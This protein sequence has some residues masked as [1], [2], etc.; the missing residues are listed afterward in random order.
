MQTEA[1]KHDPS[2]LVAD[3]TKLEWRLSRIDIRSPLASDAW[4]VARLEL[5]HPVRG[6]VTDIGTAPGAFDAAFAAASQILAISP[7]LLAFNVKSA[8]PTKEGALAI[9]IDVEL[10]LDGQVYR[11]SSFGVDLVHCS[12]IAW[13]AAASKSSAAR[14][15]GAG[16]SRPYQVSGVDENR[17]LWIFATNDPGAA[18]AVAAEFRRDNYLEVHRVGAAA[19]EQS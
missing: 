16:S 5:H 19:A 13:L 14:N 17:D 6:R 3:A 8:A 2:Q 7:R 10:E 11:G 15:A 1:S 9:Q 4:P 18:E 12:L